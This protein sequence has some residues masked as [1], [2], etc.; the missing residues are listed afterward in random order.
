MLGRGGKGAVYRAE[1]YT[2][3]STSGWTRDKLHYGT[4]LA[5]KISHGNITS[6][7]KFTS[8]LGE[9]SNHL[10]CRESNQ[11]VRC[12]VYGQTAWFW[13][14]QPVEDERKDYFEKVYFFLQ[15]HPQST[16]LHSHDTDH[17]QP[18][19]VPLTIIGLEYL[20]GGSIR[21]RAVARGIYGLIVQDS[22]A[23]EFFQ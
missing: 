12:P 21:D 17:D 16:W 3:D 10:V 4:H 1:F 14:N 5:A 8:Q 22:E 15:I 20:P 9:V 19:A 2:F 18:E 23:L 11:T 7:G 6:Y 13:R